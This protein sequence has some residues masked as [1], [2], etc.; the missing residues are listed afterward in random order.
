ISFSAAEAAGNH[1]VVPPF[2]AALSR[3]KNSEAFLFFLFYLLPLASAIVIAVTARDRDRRAV[4]ARVVPLIAIS[5]LVDR[6]FLRD[7]L[8]TRL[9]DAIVPAVLLP[10]WLAGETA[11]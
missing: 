11:H 6:A 1:L 3:A 5:L 2:G 10:A 9:A 7:E 8:S 4:F